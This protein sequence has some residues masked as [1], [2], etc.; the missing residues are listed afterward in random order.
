MTSLIVEGLLELAQLALVQLLLL[1]KLRL[2]SIESGDTEKYR[3]E[4]LIMMSRLEVPAMVSPWPGPELPGPQLAL[5]ST[6]STDPVT[7]H[8]GLCDEIEAFGNIM[9]SEA[10]K[11]RAENKS[12]REEIEK[13]RREKAAMQA[14]LD[15]QK[16]EIETSDREFED[17]RKDRDRLRQQIAACLGNE[18]RQ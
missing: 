10:D 16:L 8:R 3:L 13:L 5:P 1:L 4:R 7:F 12:L 6:E 18:R 2:Q 15:E 9:V 11:L 17:M 14:Q